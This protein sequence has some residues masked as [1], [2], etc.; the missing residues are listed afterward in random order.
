MGDHRLSRPRTAE[1]ARRSSLSLQALR[2]GRA[3]DASAAGIDKPGLLR[4][5]QGHILAE[6]ELIG[7]YERK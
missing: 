7:T 6:A 1:G 4:A 5:M 3:P 2:P